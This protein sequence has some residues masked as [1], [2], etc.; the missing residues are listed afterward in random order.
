MLN[1]QGDHRAPGPPAEAA[2][3]AV[4]GH[5]EDDL[6]IGGGRSAIGTIVERASRSTLLVHL[7]GWRVGVPNRS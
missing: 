6:I 1:T 3:R 2:D 5:W 7:P 4:S